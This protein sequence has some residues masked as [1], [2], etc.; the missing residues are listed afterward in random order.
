MTLALSLAL[1]TA[2]PQAAVPSPAPA[3]VLVP[4]RAGL[5]LELSE[6]LNGEALTRVQLNKM[7]DE[8]LPVELR[9]NPD[10][11][12]MEKLYPGALVA[13]IDGMRPVIVSKT[14]E[15]LPGLWKE[16][17]PVY[18]NA[19]SEAE[20]KQLL[21]FYRGPTGKRVIEAM[22]RGADYSQAIV[23]SINS[24]DTKVTAN[25]FKSGASAG[26]ARVIQESNPED[27]NAMIA[28][29]KTDAGKK[30]PGITAVVLQCSADWSNRIMPQIQPDVN[31][32]AQAAI[33][34][35]IAKGKKP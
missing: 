35:F 17:A 28:L 29:M 30:L 1:L 14:L 19:L 27:I 24:G 12:A 11:A 2:V 7:L 21:A 20:L 6:T 16:V 18:A 22:G 9:K 31:E 15:A 8:T 26:V 34:N 4:S 33:E 32:A 23:R 10:V 5:A 13:M 3:T 25:D